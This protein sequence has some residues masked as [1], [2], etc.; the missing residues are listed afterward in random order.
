MLS[1][2]K[3]LQPVDFRF[4]DKTR[5]MKDY[6]RFLNSSTVVDR[7]QDFLKNA[8]KN[9]LQESSVQRQNPRV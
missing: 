5:P 2:G 3:N 7:N 8:N 4:H 9:V 1:F 6:L